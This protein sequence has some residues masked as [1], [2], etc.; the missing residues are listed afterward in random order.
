MGHVDIGKMSGRERQP[1]TTAAAGVQD[2]PADRRT[3]IGNAYPIP[4]RQGTMQRD[5]RY[6]PQVVKA[7][8]MMLRELEEHGESDA[9]RIARNGPD[10]QGWRIGERWVELPVDNEVVN[11]DPK[12]Q[13][14]WQE[15]CTLA[16]EVAKGQSIRLL[17]HCRWTRQQAEGC[18]RCHCEPTAEHIEQEARRQQAR[19]E[20]TTETQ[21]QQDVNTDINM[22]G[23]ETE[24]LRARR[25]RGAPPPPLPT[26]NGV[27][28]FAASAAERFHPGCTVATTTIEETPANATTTAME[29]QATN[30]N[31]IAVARM[32]RLLDE[33]GTD[34]WPDEW[35]HEG[36]TT[37]NAYAH[38]V[39]IDDATTTLNNSQAMDGD[40]SETMG[41]KRPREEGDDNATTAN[42][43]AEEQRQ[44]QQQRQTKQ[45][46]STAA[47][48]TDD[49]THN[50]S[51]GGDTGDGVS[52]AGDDGGGGGMCDSSGGKRL[53]D[54][55]GDD[56]PAQ[57]KARESGKSKPCRR[58]PPPVCTHA[59]TQPHTQTSD[60]E[61]AA[62]AGDADVASPA[63]ATSG[64][65][66][67]RPAWKKNK[68]K[69]KSGERIR[70]EANK[71]S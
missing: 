49:D 51:E 46:K 29:E 20:R 68:G 43:E 56:E 12:G 5:E 2:V 15:V 11:K 9:R 63:E 39:Q 69:K 23:L 47:R 14:R 70:R 19:A 33:V 1:T 18:R 36:A 31:A 3:W 30:D 38:N 16:A 8:A 66:E 64:G 13:K 44:G 37:A 10:G 28:D 48:E 35:P 27:P 6:R 42:G 26:G 45:R 54:A 24:E 55:E 57:K 67:Q 53:R 22:R 60:G 40:S 61:E 17:C 25:L 32:Q 71:R 34:E 62:S 65:A 41:Q 59:R 7:M 58:A 52:G 4:Y 21:T 50:S